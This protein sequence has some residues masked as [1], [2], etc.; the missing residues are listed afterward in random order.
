MSVLRGAALGMM[1][2]AASMRLS[3]GHSA[4]N[5]P[6]MVSE[7][8]GQRQR[9]RP[10]HINHQRENFAEI[11]HN[12][13]KR[14]DYQRFILGN[15]HSTKQALERQTDIARQIPNGVHKPFERYDCSHTEVW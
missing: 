11:T 5:W 3:L 14:T 13:P 12:C 10:Q 1:V 4:R 8:M 15:P 9:M 7:L 6:V 2:T